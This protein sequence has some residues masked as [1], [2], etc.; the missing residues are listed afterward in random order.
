MLEAPSRPVSLA[1]QSLGMRVSSISAPASIAG[2]AC[3]VTLA[4]PLLAGSGASGGPKTALH[5]G[6][7]Q[8]GTLTLFDLSEARYPSRF[9]GQRVPGLLLSGRQAGTALAGSTPAAVSVGTV[10]RW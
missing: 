8:G 1:C 7:G 10:S 2:R 3:V 9:Q 4:C 5:W 6:A